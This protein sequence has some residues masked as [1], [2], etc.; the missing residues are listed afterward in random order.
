LGIRL[1]RR[2]GGL[3][4]SQQ[5]DGP[6]TLPQIARARG[7]ARQRIQKVA[8]AAHAADLVHFRDNSDHK[9]SWIVVLTREGLN[10]FERI[11]RELHDAAQ[12]IEGVFDI[13][14]LDTA[15]RVLLDL[16]ENLQP[17]AR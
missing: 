5:L 4:R 8:A 11:S 3:L 9:Q 7:M 13:R 12:E 1:I 10:T 17:R 2:H 16:R 15:L 6:R 14:H